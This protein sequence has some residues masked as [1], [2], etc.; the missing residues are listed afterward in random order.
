MLDDDDPDL[1][2]R[3]E[4]ELIGVARWLSSYYPLAAERLAAIDETK[5]HGGGGSANLLAMLAVDEAARCGSRERTIRRA[6]RALAM[7]VLEDEEAI[8]FPH[9]VNALF[10]A[11]ETDEP[12]LPTKRP[13]SRS[14]G[15]AIPFGSRTCSA[16]W[17]TFACD[18]GG[19]SMRRW[20]SARDSS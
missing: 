11:G 8:G 14:G 7:G 12:V 2:E 19:F 3:F 4:A 9:A 5:L 13:Y 18:K 20:I 16:S 6:R 10:I 17:R 15:A 1:G